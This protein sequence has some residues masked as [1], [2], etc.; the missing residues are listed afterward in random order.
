[1]HT[2]GIPHKSLG[3]KLLSPGKAEV[4]E[5]GSSHSPAMLWF[6]APRASS[7]LMGCPLCVFLCVSRNHT[8]SVREASCGL[9]AENPGQGAHSW[10]RSAAVAASLLP[11]PVAPP[12]MATAQ[13]LVLPPTCF[14]VYC[15]WQQDT[16]NKEAASELQ[17]PSFLFH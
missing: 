3:R 6:F 4:R 2:P 10:E 13:G 11:P 5:L 12:L 7:F 16:C 15:H 8:A 9:W 1:M 17:L 14:P